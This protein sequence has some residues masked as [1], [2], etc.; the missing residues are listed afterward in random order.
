MTIQKAL[1]EIDALVKNTCAT[2]QKIGWLSKVD[3]MVKRIIYDTH[4]GAPEFSGYTGTTPPD[5]QL[6][7]PAPY[8]ELYL[9]Y[10]EAMIHKYNREYEA[11]NNAIE[12][13]QGA[14]EAYGNE[15]HRTHMPISK[16]NFR[17]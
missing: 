3:G 4:E 10:L 6:L 17:W 15:W 7:V 12:D 13:F 1:T 2:E 16:G 5:T 8:D 9:S 14:F 11:Y